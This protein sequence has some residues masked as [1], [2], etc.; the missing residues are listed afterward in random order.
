MAM[1]A[2]VGEAAQRELVTPSRLS[3]FNEVSLHTLGVLSAEP[4]TIMLPS[5]EKEAENT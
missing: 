1:A 2:A 3:V 4:L 5:C